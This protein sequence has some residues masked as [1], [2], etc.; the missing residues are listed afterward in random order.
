MPSAEM[1]FT[2]YIT[3]FIILAFSSSVV[4][5]ATSDYATKEDTRIV[6]WIFVTSPVWPLAALVLILR[7]VL[8]AVSTVK[9]KD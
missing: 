7:T 4:L 6:S 3:F 2:V 8:K 5:W 1:L 9:D